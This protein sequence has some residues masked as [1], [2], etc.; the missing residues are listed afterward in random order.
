MDGGNVPLLIRE[1]WGSSFPQLR[2]QREISYG[3]KRE[4]GEKS[5][6]K[7]GIERNAMTS[8]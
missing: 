8:F 7:C 5:S 2:L 3:S 6:I 4:E 1:A